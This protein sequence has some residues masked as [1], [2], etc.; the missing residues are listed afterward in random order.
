MLHLDFHPKYVTPYYGELMNLNFTSKSDNAIEILFHSIQSIAKEINDEMLITMLHAT[1]R[2][3]KVAAWIIGMD[4][5]TH[6]IKELKMFVRKTGIVYS[7]HVLLNLSLLK[8]INSIQT[9]NEFIA[10]QINYY[11]NQ[12]NIVFLESSSI[13]W[14]ISIVGYLD[15]NNDVN[16]LNQLYSSELWSNFENK[17]QTFPPPLYKSIRRSFEPNFYHKEINRMMDLMNRNDK[18]EMY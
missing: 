7:E 11:L 5:R 12:G 15:K 4:R 8:G 17:L 13:D 9:M 3:S 2:P 6:L 18:L 16:H 10:R 1:Y 14:A